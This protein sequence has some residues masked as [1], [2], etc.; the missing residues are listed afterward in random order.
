M[1]TREEKHTTNLEFCDAEEMGTK[2]SDGVQESGI[3][4]EAVNYL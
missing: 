1:G 4:L 3:D 2:T